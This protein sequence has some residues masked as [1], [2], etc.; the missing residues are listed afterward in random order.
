MPTD[1]NLWLNIITAASFAGIV[2]VVLLF[3]LTIVGARKRVRNIADVESKIGRQRP[4]RFRV[5]LAGAIPQSEKEQKSLE[6]DLKR[7]GFYGPNAI[8][9]FLATRNFIVVGVI[10]LGG[11][12]AILADPG[13][14]LPKTIL[15]ATAV[16]AALAYILP[17]SLLRSQAN[18]RLGRI[19]RGLPDALD[20]IRMCLT[21]GLP[22]R[23]SL[24]R[25]SHE[26]EFFHPDVAVELEVVRRHAE[27]DTMTKALKEFARR[28][29]A[30]D[31]NALASLV[32]Q[33]ER[34]GTHVAVAVTDFADSVRR[35]FRQRAEERAS[36]STVKMLF[37]VIFCLAPPVFILLLGSPILQLRNFV[38]EAHA[39]GGVLN[40]DSYE[41]LELGEDAPQ[42]P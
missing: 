38:K 34:T 22:L 6:Q 4:S 31:V 20:I 40:P 8:I 11:S 5:A 36:K 14:T 24:E 28:M 27:A 16:T 9:E 33:T 7:A 30:P 39:P 18:R 41:S 25:V 10:V 37:P 12:L 3:G 35:Q 19:Q 17:R 13:S 26:V 23:D 15:I 29:N 2:I 21:G 42:T 32:S 1:P